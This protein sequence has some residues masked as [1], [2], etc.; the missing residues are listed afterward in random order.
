MWTNKVLFILIIT[1]GLISGIFGGSFIKGVW[2]IFNQQKLLLL[3]LFMPTSIHSDIRYLIAS[4]KFI[5]WNFEFL[6]VFDPGFSFM[7]DFDTTQTHDP[8][9]EIEI[10]SGSTVYIYRMYIFLSILCIILHVISILS[11]KI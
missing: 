5:L 3:M 8:L 4:Q 2:M 1:N 9:R 6:K 7:S 10:E 11:W